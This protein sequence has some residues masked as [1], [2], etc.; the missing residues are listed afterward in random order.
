MT[1]LNNQKELTQRRLEQAH[2]DELKTQRTLFT[3]RS[4]TFW[5]DRAAAIERQANDLLPS[6]AFELA[7]RSSAADSLVVLTRDGAPAYPAPLPPPSA[8]PRRST[9][10]LGPTPAAWKTVRPRNA[11]R[12]PPSLASPKRK[13]DTDIAARAHPVPGPLP[14][15]RPAN[16][17]N[18]LRLI[19]QQFRA[20]RFANATDLQGR[21]IAAD[22]QLLAL[23]LAPKGDAPAV[24]RTL[25]AD[26]TNALPSSPATL[27]HER[28]ARLLPHPRRPKPSP[29]NTW[30]PGDLR[31]D[32]PGL[33]ATPLPDTWRIAAPRWSRGRALPHPYPW[34]PPCT[35][36]WKGTPIQASLP[37]HTPEGQAPDWQIA[38]PH[39]RFRR[40]FPNPDRLL[41][42]G[43]LPG[44]RR[45]SHHRPHRRPGPAPPMASGPPQD[46][47][48]LPP[49]LTNS[50]RPSPPCACWWTICWKMSSPTPSRRATTWN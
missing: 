36:W 33:R 12:P 37:P 28:A 21:V 4:H 31:H 25:I 43:G 32:A 48:G 1:P 6:A 40:F 41:S 38:I 13:T 2:Q 39:T 46:R 16:Q 24:L 29:R 7:V 49:S 34:S 8:D 20:G 45:R 19:A 26:Y 30:K 23:H 35:S 15:P 14:G 42:L 9:A 27:P 18:A 17:P 50:K 11:K 22:A 5:K 3:E 10:R 47:P 44:H